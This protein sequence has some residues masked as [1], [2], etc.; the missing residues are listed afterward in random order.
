MDAKNTYQRI[1]V[2]TQIKYQHLQKN[3]PFPKLNIYRKY[4]LNL[5]EWNAGSFWDHTYNI[6]SVKGLYGLD[7]AQKFADV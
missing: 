2:H 3:N 6:M 7:K 5:K 4:E 1:Y